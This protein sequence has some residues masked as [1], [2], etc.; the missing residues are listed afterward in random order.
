M[1]ARSDA[2]DANAV[3]ADS[4]NGSRYMRSVAKLIGHVRSGLL[5]FEATAFLVRPCAMSEVPTVHV[6]DEPVAIV[7]NAVA[8]NLTGVRPHVRGQI[9][10]GVC[11]AGV[12]VGAAAAVNFL[13]SLGGGTTR[14]ACLHRVFDVLHWRGNALLA[15]LWQGLAAI[16]GVTLYGP[17]PEAPRTP[18]VAFTVENVASTL[19]ARQLAERGLFLSHGDFYALTVVERLNLLPEGLVRAGCACY[20]TPEE[21]DRLVEG[22]RAVVRG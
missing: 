7:V 17:P 4:G 6:V 8:R 16:E 3:I 15:R 9:R 2:D 18:T 22:V 13:A 10:V 11:D 21:I 19:V 1:R 14:R 12:D 20:T 5:R